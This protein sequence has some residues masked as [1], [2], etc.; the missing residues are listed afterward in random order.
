MKIP[1]LIATVFFL[2][3][4]GIAVGADQPSARA[5]L[6]AIS[7]DTDS[8]KFRNERTSPEDS[9]MSC[10]EF[11]GKNSFGA[12]VGFRRFIVSKGTVLIDDGTQPKF[13]A[14]WARFCSR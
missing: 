11:N 13:E 12:Y 5:K 2:G 4:T 1:S 14:A 3:I 9:T 8:L 10:G 6:R 7:K